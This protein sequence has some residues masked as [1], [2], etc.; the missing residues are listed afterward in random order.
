MPH[1][2]F[3]ARG[4]RAADRDQRG[5]AADHGGEIGEFPRA[6]Q[7]AALA[8]FLQPA[9]RR[10]F[11]TFAAALGFGH[12][13]APAAGAPTKLEAASSALLIRVAMPDMMPS[14]PASSTKKPLI[15]VMVKPIPNKLSCGAARVTT[16]SARLTI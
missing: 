14:S 3:Q 6:R 2:Q 12:Q 9:L 11:G 4:N 16:P 13:G 8:R 7:L 15:S 5:A 1:H 10:F